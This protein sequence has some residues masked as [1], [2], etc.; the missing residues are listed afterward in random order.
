MDL[1][2]GFSHETEYMPGAT[3]IYGIHGKCTIS[4]VEA[5]QVGGN[6]LRF[7]KLEKVKSTFART[8]R[9]EPAIWL[10]VTNARDRGLRLPMSAADVE[11][12]M[13][14]IC[15]REYYFPLAEPW[16]ANQARIETTIR[17]E[18]FMGLAK[19]VSF[20]EVLKRRQVVPES[21]LLRFNE[22]VAKLFVRE[23]CDAT[24]KLPRD[25][26]AEIERGIKHKLQPDN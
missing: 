20:T 15:N 8:N 10:P 23:V 1:Q 18:G 14:M 5:R 21:E 13:A 26:Y 17:L 4:S 19:A 7:Y 11:T 25:V 24:G 3:V 9:L 2:T 16:L 6:T 22:N 12:A